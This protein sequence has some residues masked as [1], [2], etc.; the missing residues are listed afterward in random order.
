MPPSNFPHSM[1]TPHRA[2]D[3]PMAPRLVG[4]SND[5]VPFPHLLLSTS[6]SRRQESVGSPS[7]SIARLPTL[8]QNVL[9]LSNNGLTPP[10]GCSI[11][12]QSRCIV[13]GEFEVARRPRTARPGKVGRL[14]PP[15]PTQVA[16]GNKRRET[17]WGGVLIFS[18]P[19]GS[20]PSVPR[21]SRFGI[22][23]DDRSSYYSFCHIKCKILQDACLT[24]NLTD[25]G[26]TM[27]WSDVHRQGKIMPPPQSP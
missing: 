10:S 16:S 6:L 26:M 27:F 17:P 15:Q 24:I 25:R 21:S 23:I 11:H 12:T 1:R 3:A 8:P 9:S 7:A 19:A 13:A 4:I 14:H 20:H 2:K 5:G 18:T 22:R